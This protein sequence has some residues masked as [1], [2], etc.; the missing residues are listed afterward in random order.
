MPADSPVTGAR[1]ASC[2]HVRAAKRSGYP[3]VSASSDSFTSAR[4]AVNRPCRNERRWSRTSA[5]CRRYSQFVNEAAAADEHEVVC[6][7]C[8]KPFIGE[9]LPGSA[10]RYRGFKCPHCKL[11]VPAERAA[12][13]P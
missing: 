7:H 9:M 11:F 6:P 10:E 4:P 8:K 1:R 3:K 2:A 5:T 12:E 13:Q